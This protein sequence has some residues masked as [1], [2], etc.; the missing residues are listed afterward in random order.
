MREIGNVETDESDLA[1]SHQ[2]HDSKS[3]SEKI[4]AG[5]QKTGLT[6]LGQT[7]IDVSTSWVLGDILVR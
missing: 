2:K 6:E 5:Y 4:A 7:C 3:V 1:N